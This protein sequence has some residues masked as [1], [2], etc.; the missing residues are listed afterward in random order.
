MMHFI[1]SMLI[2]AAFR[3][4]ALWLLRRSAFTTT[5]WGP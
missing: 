3:A 1:A 4:V 2:V 5:T